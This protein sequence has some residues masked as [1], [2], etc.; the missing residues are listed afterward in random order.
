[1]ARAN[2]PRY[3]EKTINEVIAL[4]NS[5]EELSEINRTYNLKDTT[6]YHFLKA[7]GITPRTKR[8]GT[9]VTEPEVPG[10]N[11]RHG[12]T[13]LVVTTDKEGFVVKAEPFAKANGPTFEVSFSGI[14]EISANSIEEA[15]SLARKRPMIGRIHG[16]R[17][18]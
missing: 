17:E 4:Y 6:I 8:N 11:F 13:D 14:I 10:S 18:K 15:I 7:R 5:G 12:V 1:M 9:V 2:H 16:I 3:S